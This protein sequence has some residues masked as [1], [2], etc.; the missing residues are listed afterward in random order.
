MYKRV[1]VCEADVPLGWEVDGSVGGATSLGWEVDGLEGGAGV[2]LREVDG[3]L[4]PDISV[5]MTVR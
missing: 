3:L 4:R 2:S 1:P 5:Q